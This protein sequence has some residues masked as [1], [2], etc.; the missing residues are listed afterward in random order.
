MKGIDRMKKKTDYIIPL[1]VLALLAPGSGFGAANNDIAARKAF[2]LRDAVIVL[3][4]NKQGDLRQ[5]AG[6]L[7]Y[8]AGEITGRKIRLVNERQAAEI[9]APKIYVGNTA[10]MV[11][12][13]LK[14]CKYDGYW[15]KAQPDGSL[16]IIGSSDKGTEFGI[17]GFLQDIC[18]VRF[19]LPERTGTYVPH[20]RDLLIPLKDTL[21]NPYFEQR[22]FITI[23]AYDRGWLRHNRLIERYPSKHGLYK[24][25]TEKYAKDHPEY[26]AYSATLKKRLLPGREGRLVYSQQP[27]MTNPDVI[28]IVSDYAIDYFKN[29]PDEICLNL[30]PNDSTHYCQCPS[31]RKVRGNKK[32][33]NDMG[34]VS[35]SRLSLY[36]YNQVADRVFKVFPDKYIGI[37][38]YNST[39]SMPEGMK[40]HPHIVMGVL[41]YPQYYF[42]P[43]S[44]NFDEII[45]RKNSV[46]SLVAAG[47][48]YGTGFLVPNL[49]MNLEE[50]FL[51]FC[52]DRH[53]LGMDNE[54]GANW[55]AIGMKDYLFA[56]KMW[57]PNLR[58][59]D[60]LEEFC[61]NMFGDGAPDMLKFYELACSTWEN[62]KMEYP[63]AAQMQKSTAQFNLYNERICR[64]L[65]THL[66]NASEKAGNGIQGKA[67]LDRKIGYYRLLCDIQKL[68]LYWKQKEPDSLP[69]LADWCI[70]FEKLRRDVNAR[71]QTFREAGF[72]NDMIN[73]WYPAVNNAYLL[74]ERCH[75]AGDMREWKRFLKAVGPLPV[76]Q[77][78]DKNKDAVFSAEN[79]LK[80]P[81]FELKET[82]YSKMYQSAGI[83]ENWEYAEWGGNREPGGRKIEIR[84][85]AAEL[86]GIKGRKFSSAFPVITQKIP[87]KKDD[88]YLFICESM[89]KDG[90]ADMV[91]SW[92][93]Q[94]QRPPHSNDFKPF[95]F[96]VTFP[97][98]SPKNFLYA[99]GAH[100]YGLARYRNPRFIRIPAPPEPPNNELT[101][102]Y[103]E[104][105]VLPE[106]IIL[107]YAQPMARTNYRYSYEGAYPLKI[108][109]FT[110]G[111]SRIIVTGFDSWGR[112]TNKVR[113]LFDRSTTGPES[114]SEFTYRSQSKGISTTSF[115]IRAGKGKI[116]RVELIPVSGR[117]QKASGAK[118]K[119][120]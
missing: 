92:I 45:K 107:T 71:F 4:E 42:D 65:L 21:E 56:R 39:R 85:Q 75:R 102:Q 70:G 53:L 5:A 94:S 119:S 11:L 20:S 113:K 10:G 15:F 90:E 78:L 83:P 80:N 41:E 112:N 14:Q 50:K 104:P 73:K 18:G 30:G 43:A 44:E 105:P 2:R 7:A 8:Y 12:P 109:I 48:R 88:S 13:D 22:R 69:E 72:D 91:D 81:T 52:R 118:K 96:F 3:P 106:P 79:L 17:Y 110:E 32:E 111:K 97:K 95:V 58:S 68:F 82:P 54:I 59:R 116:K 101:M 49:A 64:Q 120:K 29:N 117:T 87:I 28:R 115:V 47:W 55:I 100:G 86:T 19:Y 34:F 6:E 16:L 60:M 63:H 57:N 108:R 9:K 66:E 67:W 61:R 33:I 31:C 25:I 46:P 38:G 26:F 114:V 76:L 40:L 84:N 1:V 36:F 99:L 77:W 24:V 89:F 37:I 35:D 62:Q 27:C 98:N 103:E 23:S 74:L 51:D 93:T